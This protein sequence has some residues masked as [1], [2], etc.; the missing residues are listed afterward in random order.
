MAIYKHGRET[1]L[2]QIEIRTNM[3]LASG[4]GGTRTQTIGLQDQRNDH[5][6][7]LSF[8][9]QNHFLTFFLAPGL[10]TFAKGEGERVNG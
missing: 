6:V 2:D 7:M 5:S 10:R 4:Y 8:I 9:Y 1:E 3:V